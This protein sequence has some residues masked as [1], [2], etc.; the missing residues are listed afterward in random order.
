MQINKSF[1]AVLAA[2]IS[3]MTLPAAGAVNAPGDLQI[4]IPF[5]KVILKNG[6]T[7]IVHEDHKAPIVAVDLWYH[8]GSK[9]EKPGKTGFAHLFEHLMFT[10][11]EHLK[12][13]GNQRVFYETMERLGATNPNG[14]TNPDWTDFFETVP[15]N[16]LDVALWI[17]SDRMGHLLETIDQTR[18]DKQ[19]GVVQN[20]KRQGE[21]EPYGKVRELIAKGTAPAGHPYSWTTIGSMEDLDAAAL[22]DVQAWFKSYYGAANVVLVLAGDIDTDT[23]IKKAEQYF[24][25]IPAGPPVARYRK[26]IPELR[27]TRR[28]TLSDRVPLARIYL[29]WDIPAYG[30]PDAV[31]LGMVSDVLASGKT[32]RL[33]KRLVYDEQLATDVAAWASPLEISGLFGI[34]VTARPG[35]DLARIEKVV[36]EELAR[37]LARGPTPNEVQ[38]SRAQELATFVRSTERIGGFGGKADI[39]ALNETFRGRPDF[40]QTILKYQREATARD[41]QK[42]ARQWLT[43]DVFILEVHPYPDYGITGST[44]DRSK[45][46]APGAPPEG[47]FPAL[48]RAT[49]SNGL[50]I[51][52]AERHATPLVDLDLQLD[53]G[54]AADQ[55]AVPGTAR[56]AMEMLDEGTTHRTAL[57]ISGELAALGAQLNAGSALDTSSVSLA[58]L[59]STLDP[60]L[61]IFADVILNPSF[62]ETDFERLQKLALARIQR[63][64]TEPLDMARRVLP[65]LLYGAGHAYANPMTGSGTEPSVAGLKRADLK[66]FHD[67]WFKP[68]NATLIIV[69]DTTLKAIT[70]KLEKLFGQWK[71]GTVPAKNI[72]TVAQ[73]KKAAI[74]LVDRPGSLQ[75]LII[76]GHV[77]PPRADPDAIAIDTMNTILGGAV[78]SRID[79]NLREEKHWSYGSFTIFSWAKGQG[80]FFVYA[81]VQTDKTR[82]AMVEADKEL[83]GILGQQPITPAELEKAK[84][85]QTLSLPGSWET[86]DAIVDSIAQIVRFGLP[87][88]YFATYAGKVRGLSLPEVTSAARKVLHPD[89]L[90][91][92]IVGDRARI[93]P[94]I[95]ELG[96]GPV[97]LLDADGNPVK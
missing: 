43:E 25:D 54:G 5:K 18:L 51:I 6:L 23:A 82:E 26:W 30:E 29:V 36:D 33:Y 20:E 28:E 1:A 92:V 68:N 22:A 60:A 70:P 57:E 50:K 38:R 93:E 41:L 78:S 8:V 55:L 86:D 64:K 7:V 31:Y 62:P 4:Q 53:A 24:G 81:P 79:M 10:G 21:N 48:Q 11:S 32:S 90:V 52:L 45:L 40:Y 34:Q 80:L 59:A 14:T 72:A 71:P 56:L 84:N 15:T 47:K 73:Q 3:L 91:W 85:S 44:V 35:G 66:Q 77:A 42:A 96:W 88:D 9:N 87:D 39:L 97:Q 89:Q 58:T 49:L 37:F 67:T 69:G 61:Q 46:P 17:E 63:E 76:A 75:S 95:R 94:G 16:A 19:R 27:G 2:C 74:C 65:R 13:E 12:G 83:R